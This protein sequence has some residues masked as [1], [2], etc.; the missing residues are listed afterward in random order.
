MR[1]VLAAEPVNT[2]R[3][4]EVDIGKA[5]MVLMLPFIHCIIECC[6]DAQFD[7]GIPFLF[8]T[9]IGGA[10]SAPMYLFCMGI[11]MVYSRNATTAER[12]S[13]GIRLIGIFYLA[14]TFRYLIPY[15][16]GYGITGDREQFIDPLIYRWLGNDVLLFAGMAIIVIALF[17]H[18][19]LSDRMM[20]EISAVLLLA[21]NLIGDVD[22]GSRFGNIFLGYFIGTTDTDE[23]VVSDFP[24]LTWLIVPVCGYAF[25]KVLVRVRDKD[26]FYGRLIIPM[27]AI[28][29]IWYPIGNHFELGV[30]D[31]GQNAYY[32]MMAWDCVCYLC[33]TVGMLSL[34]H[35][36]SKLLGKGLKAFLTETS[37]NITSIYCIHWVFVI[38]ITNVILY[39]VNGTQIL[40]VPYVM[41]IALG[42]DI[43][44]WIIA[45]YW[46]V[47]KN[48]RETRSAEHTTAA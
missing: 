33:L 40:P 37:R 34:W 43:A 31:Y 47:Y 28:P 36:V 44:A 41:L 20:I 3:Q 29:A 27:L 22:T 18:W 42:I 15:L 13:R 26:R 2:E 16:I 5:S 8:D 25:G 32:H 7:Y 24:L 1:D 38:C 11:C 46:S 6:T 23:M 48:G 35:F 39:I 30:F 12:V 45:H 4:L 10:F 17:I 19:G 21:T 9:I 14:Q